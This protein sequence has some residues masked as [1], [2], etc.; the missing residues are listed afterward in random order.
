MTVPTQV[1]LLVADT[2]IVTMDAQR[3]I[4]VDG[5]LAVTG[6]KIV[7]IGKSLDLKRAYTARETVDGSRFVITPGLVN[8]HVHVTGEPLTRGLV[9]DNT[10]FEENVFQWLVPVHNAYTEADERLACRVAALEMLRSGTTCFLEAGTI[11]FLDAVV[12]GLAETGIRAR[13]GEWAWDFSPVDQSHPPAATDAAVRVL[14][15]ELRRYPGGDDKRIAAWPILIGHMTCSGPLWRA[16]KELA[17]ANGAGVAAHMSPVKADPDWFLARHGV[18]PLEYLAELGA[19][20][21]NVTFTHAVHLNEFEVAILAEARANVCHCATSALKGAYGVTAVGRFPEMQAQGV[22]IALGTDGNNNSN[23][24]DLMRATYL[25]AALF[26]DSRRDPTLFP[27]EQALECATLNGAR[28]LGMS[29]SIG[30]L[31]A[32]KKADFVAHDTWRSEWRPLFNVPNQ[33][34]WSADGRGVHSVWVD[35]RRVVDDYRCTTIDEEKILAEAQIA[36]E[37]IVARAGL[38]IKSRWP[39]V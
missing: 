8:A 26:K 12:D 27:T 10:G 31:E 21:E 20:G 2:T 3:R 14:E 4:V 7:A 33:L 25:I 11:R 17:D 34:V 23:Y 29:D 1:D 6:D 15:D 24:H 19:V 28:V 39:I 13:V 36:G 32:G 30:S 18:R 22:N 37:A 9:P 16:A 38:P 5:A 35:G